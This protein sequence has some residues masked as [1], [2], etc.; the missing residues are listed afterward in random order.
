M[1]SIAYALCPADFD[2]VCRETDLFFPIFF[3]GLARD[4][5]LHAAAFAPQGAADHRPR[6]HG[7][8]VGGGRTHSLLRAVSF[9]VSGTPMP[10][11]F[12]SS[13]IC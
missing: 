9:S 6:L 2:G 5:R 13:R 7:L 10:S 4:Y 12:I 3:S 8:A 1:V 11:V